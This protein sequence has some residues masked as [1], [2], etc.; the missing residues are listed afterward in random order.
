MG[1]AMARTASTMS[2]TP[3]A[4]PTPARMLIRRERTSRRTS[5]TYGTGA[6][7]SG[8]PA[9]RALVQ[10]E[11]AAGDEIGNHTLTHAHL[12]LI[13]AGGVE[14]EVE[15]GARALVAAGAP[16]PRLFRP[17][18]GFTTRVVARVVRRARERTV[19]WGL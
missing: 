7:G 16:P 13:S 19:F 11:V 10:A 3:E 9:L 1:D 14:D 8:S 12:E 4:I 2:S 17:P 5:E 15:D 18:R 6:A